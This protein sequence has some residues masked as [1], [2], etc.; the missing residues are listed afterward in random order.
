MI[1]VRTKICLEMERLETARNLFAKATRQHDVKFVEHDENG[2]V[3]E[4]M[5]TGFMM[6]MLSYQEYTEE[7]ALLPITD[8]LQEL[9][10]MLDEIRDFFE[11]FDDDEDK[12]RYRP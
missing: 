8:S 10:A 4:I 1:P 9:Q 2:P 12:E 7:L 11:K 3:R 6:G 5:M